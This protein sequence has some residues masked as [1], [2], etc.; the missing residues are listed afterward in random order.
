VASTG[1]TRRY[2][3][4]K[5]VLKDPGVKILKHD[6]MV[7]D[8]EAINIFNGFNMFFENEDEDSDFYLVRFEPEHI[9]RMDANGKIIAEND[10][11]YIEAEYKEAEYRDYLSMLGAI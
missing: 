1:S 8:G 7:N 2:Q 6:E 10:Q 11:A 3:V 9:V 5:F 4:K